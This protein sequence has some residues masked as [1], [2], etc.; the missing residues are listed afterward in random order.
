MGGDSAGRIDV[1]LNLNSGNFNRQ[2]QGI[3]GL[4]KKAG[5]AIAAA[6]GVKKLIDF[7]ASCI[8]LGSDLNE[9]QNVVDVTFPRMSKQVDAFA[10]NA[11]SQFGL[12]ETM[13]KKFT[14]TFG[15]M[16]KAFGFGEKAA[17]EMSTTLTGLAGD[18]A[19]F[20]NISQEDAYTKLKS[21]FTGETETLKDL[22]I[23]MTQSALDSYALANGFGKVTAKMSEAEMVALRYKFIQDKLTLA[24][25][26][27]TR[28]SDS[29]ANQVRVL[30]LQFDSLKATIGQGL[31]NVLTPVIK[32]INTI[33]GKLMSLANAFK[34]FTEMI[35]GKKGSSGGTSVTAAG[36]EEI[37]DSANHAGAAMGGAGGAAKKAAKDMKTLLGGVD[38][39]NLLGD[40]NSGGSGSGGGA[41]GYEVD[42]F[43]MGEI[44]PIPPDDSENK[45][46]ALIDKAKEFAALFKD[47]FKI[48][49]GDTSVF[50]SVRSSLDGIKESLKGIF[51]DTDV[52]AAADNFAKQLAFNLGKVSGSIVSIGAT[53]ADNLLGGFN[54]YLKQN[55]RRIKDFIISIFDIGSEIA[56]IVGDFSE[57]IAVIFSAFR[58]DSAKQITADIIGIFSSGFMGVI[59]LAGKFARDVLNVITK[60]IINNKDAIKKRIEGLLKGIQ[61]IISSI[62]DIVEKIFEKV[63]TAYDKYMKP[64]MDGLAQG[65]SNVINWLTAT[66]GRFNAA[67]GIVTGF[68]AA[69]QIV[70]LGEFIINAGGV[71]TILNNMVTALMAATTGWITHTT[72]MIADKIE[73]AAIVALYAKDFVVNLA[74]GTVELVK[75]AAQFAINTAAKVADTIAQAAMTAATVAWN[76][77]CTVA[78]TLTTAF[79]AAMAFLTSPIGLVVLAIAGLIAAG[80]LLYQ[81]WDEIQAKAAEV[82]GQIKEIISNFWKVV[83]EKTQEIWTA[84]KEF[85]SQIWENIKTRASEI[86]NGI[87][88]TLSA[89]WD[90]IKQTVEQKWNAIKDWI[91]HIWQKI[92]A[93][94]KLDEMLQIGR[95]IITKLW[96][97][98]K[99]V[100]NSVTSWLNGIVNTIKKIWNDVCDY[101]KNI[102]NKSKEAEDVDTGSSSKSKRKGSSSSGAATGPGKTISGHAS[103]GFPKS[104]E[105]FVANENGKPEMVGSWG[106]RAAVANNMQIT[107]GIAQAVQAGMR[108]TISPL[109]SKMGT[110]VER[111]TP[112][113]AITGKNE[114]QRERK[115]NNEQDDVNNEKSKQGITLEDLRGA[116]AETA[117]MIASLIPQQSQ[118]S[119]DTGTIVIP[120]YLDGSMLDEVIITAQQRKAL[121]SGGR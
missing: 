91:T 64:V 51:T 34:A 75:Q 89:I 6:F 107:Q 52:L 15:A 95:N 99:N 87:K 28:T 59:E 21:V 47:G 62:K 22:G 106:G 85:V 104:G 73:T 79:G 81:H 78:T 119:A 117:K 86:F 14:A 23:V 19:S 39:L 26:D 41:G 16:S 92:K 25:G 36:M 82:W 12:S 18:M 44:E 83:Q 70:K 35:T 105:M 101:V 57:S 66:Q 43:D 103:G 33:I 46:Q 17:Y 9:V 45:F 5:V 88:E 71:V 108:T 65:L 97:G 27:F 31:I 96:D 10:K 20:Y 56:E 7:G 54:K 2:V 24:A 113:L 68:F 42:D 116:L 121:R 120:I 100:W 37:A 49:L 55:S 114:E 48:G 67:I 3:Q 8:Q 112:R 94:F 110:F 72:A 74:R 118:Y 111:A 29:W 80:V 69:W 63:N 30:K 109:M 84:I 53:F 61:P 11:I 76:A 102:F 1:E 38:E 40:K 93:I 115:P 60:P 50:D 4:A 13:A 77:V 90:S 58:S 98:M 32:V